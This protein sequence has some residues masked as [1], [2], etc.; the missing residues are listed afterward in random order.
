MLTTVVLHL[1]PVVQTRLA[2]SHGSF[3]YAAALDLLLRLDPHL[4]HLLH[5]PARSKPFPCSPLGGTD[6]REEF[7]FLLSPDRIYTWRLTGLTSIVSQHLVR[8]TPELGG[9]RIGEAVFSIAQV[10]CASEQHPDAGQ[11]T[12]EALLERWERHSAPP[13]VTLQFL[14]PTT[15]RVGRFE[16][17]FPLPHL[18]VGLL[19]STWNAFASRPLP[20]LH[21]VLN[22]AVVLSNWRGET[23]RLHYDGPLC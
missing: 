11:E 9:I 22:E 4:S 3:A 7:D 15:F 21:E 2:I 1:R 23:K 10:S 13:T 16:R 6:R 5:E 19:L 20:N 14:T 12:Y 17:P 18:I 8:L